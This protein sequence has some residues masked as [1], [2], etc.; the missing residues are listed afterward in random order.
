MRTKLEAALDRVRPAVQM[1]GGDIHLVAWEADE[2]VVKVALSGACEGC[3]MVT[4]TMTQ[5]VERILK[6]LVPEIQAVEA[7]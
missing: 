5:G 7:I 2:G 4:M 1:D 6:E 3:S